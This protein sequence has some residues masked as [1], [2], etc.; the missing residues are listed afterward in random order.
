MKTLTYI[1]HC[2]IFSNCQS[3][4]VQPER[5]VKYAFEFSSKF[6]RQN[7]RSCKFVRVKA[8]GQLFGITNQ[9]GLS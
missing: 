3:I 4:Q 6:S 5:N 8:D 2:D 1:A 9:A 7:S